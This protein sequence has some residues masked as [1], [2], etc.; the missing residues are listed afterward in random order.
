MRKVI[1]SIWVFREAIYFSREGW[2]GIRNPCPSGKSLD[3]R[4]RESGCGAA[5]SYQSTLLAI[6]ILHRFPFDLSGSESDFAGIGPAQ[7][8][9]QRSLRGGVPHHIVGPTTQTFS[10]CDRRAEK[11]SQP[12]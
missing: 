4:E 11:F 9:P 1:N 7:I 10:G 6:K 3:A 2:T 5:A 12:N 8:A